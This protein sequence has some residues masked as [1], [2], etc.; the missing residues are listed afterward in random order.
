MDEQLTKQETLTNGRA[1]TNV[2]HISNLTRP[3]TVGQLKELLGK[4]GTLLSMPPNTAAASSEKQ[5][6]FW[7][8]SVKSH[9][10]V[11]FETESAAK[12]AR[13][14]LNN[15]AWPQSNPKSLR[16]EFTSLDELI[17]Q[18]NSGS[19][20]LVKKQQ[21]PS[22]KLLLNA[23]TGITLTVKNDNSL[24]QSGE[25]AVSAKVT[26]NGGTSKGEKENKSNRERDRSGEQKSNKER[27]RD[28]H[29]QVREW[30]LHKVAGAGARSR[31]RSPKD[32]RNAASAKEVKDKEKEKERVKR[33]AAKSDKPPPPTLDDLFRKTQA[34]P[35]VY[36]LPLSDEQ[37]L[38]KQKA[39]QKR[40]EDRLKRAEER[41]LKEQVM[42]IN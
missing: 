7:I 11:A 35:F 27:D 21:A 17:L 16:V 40:V 12:Q 32:R 20:N 24:P 34:T 41:K 5:H 39:E 31:S 25:T 14:A 30:D 4:Y 19:D 37:C 36:W 9:S 22:E 2:I 23:S 29:N 3:F 33:E 28:R 18:M 10:Y 8:N 26:Q 13:D 42:P 6:Y 15:T 38:A 1:S